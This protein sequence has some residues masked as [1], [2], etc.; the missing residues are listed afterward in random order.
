MMAPLLY[1][2]YQ[3]YADLTDPLRA[4]AK[5]GAEFWPGRL[6]APWD[7]MVRRMT[8]AWDVYALTGLTHARPPF[9]IDV[10][11]VGR[12]DVSVRE[13]VVHST[14]FC[15]LLHFRKDCDAIQPTVLV[16]APMSGHFAT[17][18]RGTVK[19]LLRDHDVYITDWHNVRDVSFSAGKFDLDDFIRHVIDFTAYLGP[20]THLLAVC[21]PAVPVL[22]ATAR[23]A[24][25]KHPTQ[26]KT[27][28]LMAGPIDTRINPTVVNKVATDNSIEW[29]ER[30]VVSVVPARFPGGG[31]RVY[32]GFLQITAFMSMNIGRHINSLWEM[33]DALV[34]QDETSAEAVRDFYE[35]YFAMADMSA[36]FYLQTV[37]KVFQEFHLPRGLLEVEG[38]LVRPET[39]K[40]TALLTI[41]GERDDICSLGQT[42]AAQDLCSGLRPYMKT[43][44]VQAGVGHYGVF[45]GRRWEGEVYPLVRDFILQHAG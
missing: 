43:H 42:L 34:E 44:H 29:F 39:I 30:N 37:R 6:C 35:E 20:D 21:Q 19:V 8:S 5:A 31:R 13:E 32:P 15:S 41:E 22:A 11:R 17:L 27:M 2:A 38:R 10:V 28:T 7:G 14:P 12:R 36:D 16:V 24:E 4:L 23:M 40:K 26:P 25:D 45:N 9:G 18:L 33:Y 3:A 1:Q